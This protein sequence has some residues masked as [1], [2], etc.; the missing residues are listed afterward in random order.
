M[1]QF[2][3]GSITPLIVPIIIDFNISVDQATRLI[4]LN[5][6][7]TGVGVRGNISVVRLI[8]LTVLLELLLD[9][10]RAKDWQKTDLYRLCT[11]VLWLW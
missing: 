10:P 4:T 5:I 8:A 3:N 2:A 6:L 9:S 11:S 1:S 7:F